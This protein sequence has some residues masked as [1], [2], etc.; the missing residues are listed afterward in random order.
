M[1][2]S[3]SDE[4]ATDGVRAVLHDLQQHCS[5]HRQLH[6]HPADGQQVRHCQDPVLQEVPQCREARDCHQC[7]A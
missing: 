7:Q 3:Q 2:K 5:A 4:V 6:R 1:D